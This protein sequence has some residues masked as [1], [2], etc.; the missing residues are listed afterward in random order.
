MTCQS[1]LSAKAFVNP[2]GTILLGELNAV[3]RF[4][5]TCASNAKLKHQITISS[6]NGR[7][8]ILAKHVSGRECIRRSCKC[9]HRSASHRLQTSPSSVTNCK[10]Q[11]VVNSLHNLA[12]QLP[13][14]QMFKCSHAF[15]ERWTA[16]LINFFFKDSVQQQNRLD[17]VTAE[18]A[19]VI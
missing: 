4:W 11:D 5:C 18:W 1:I 19:L 10:F 8:K 15:S 2:H 14:Q 3:N 6:A 12:C 13:Q 9:L 16:V 7:D 17:A